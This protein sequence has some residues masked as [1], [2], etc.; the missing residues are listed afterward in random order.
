MFIE[1][2]AKFKRDADYNNFCSD[3]TCEEVEAELVDVDGF[4]EVFDYTVGGGEMTLDALFQIEIDFP[5]APIGSHPH[6]CA[7][8]CGYCDRVDSWS[9]GYARKSEDIMEDLEKELKGIQGFKE[10]ELC[11]E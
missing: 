4:Q 10:L 8:D 7:S 6:W 9:E 1:L 2:N 11:D 3:A 5:E